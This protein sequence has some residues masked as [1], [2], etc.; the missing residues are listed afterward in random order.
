MCISNEQIFW[1]DLLCDYD[2]RSSGLRKNH[3]YRRAFPCT[4]HDTRQSICWSVQWLTSW[5]TSPCHHHWST[6]GMWWDCNFL[7]RMYVSL[8][9]CTWSGRRQCSAQCGRSMGLAWHVEQGNSCYQKRCGR[10][11]LL[12]CETYAWGIPTT[13]MWSAGLSSLADITYGDIGNPFCIKHGVAA[14]YHT[15]WGDRKLL[16]VG[17]QSGEFCM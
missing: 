16:I 9:V 6:P 8:C 14:K 11:W 15:A 12:W 4:L 7:G 1:C 10:A 5:N 17:L 13:W 3:T 2:A